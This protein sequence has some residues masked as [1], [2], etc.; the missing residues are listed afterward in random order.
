[1]ESSGSSKENSSTSNLGSNIS[2]SNA[3]VNPGAGNPGSN[4]TY[5]K[6]LEIEQFEDKLI[7]Q[8]YICPLCTGVYNNPVVDGCGHVFCQKCIDLSMTKTIYC[9]ISYRD[10]GK[11]SFHQIPFISSIISKHI[12]NCKNKCGWKKALS[13]YQAHL[14]EDCPNVLQKCKF[15]NCKEF[16]LRSEKT[17]HEA[18]CEFRLIMCDHCK[19]YFAFVELDK[20]LA[21]SCP[22]VKIACLQDCSLEI[23]RCQMEDHIKQLC[24][25]TLVQCVFSEFGCSENFK[26]K[27]ENSHYETRSI[28]HLKVLGKDVIQEN[29]TLKQ[30]ISV[31]EEEQKLLQEAMQKLEKYVENNIKLIKSQQE[32][33]NAAEN[34][35]YINII[36]KFLL[37]LITSTFFP[38]LY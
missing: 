8:D 9:P 3:S 5:T 11:D 2:S 31:L 7:I 19:N 36:K 25:N 15:E 21:T 26:R 13:F 1:M 38:S 30:K 32:Y 17:Q 20:H 16:F 24:E 10:L 18:N 33:R 23:E 34:D 14:D 27:D 4:I 29:K 6:Y 22:N 12:I 28:A 35:M 37:Q